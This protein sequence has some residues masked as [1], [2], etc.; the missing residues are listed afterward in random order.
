M[1]YYTNMHLYCTRYL[2]LVKLAIFSLYSL[3]KEMLRD[4]VENKA[5][6]VS[7]LLH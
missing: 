3:I 1:H 2:P 7:C 4:D 5:H 6:E